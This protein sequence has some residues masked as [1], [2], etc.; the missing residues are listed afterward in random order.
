MRYLPLL[1]L[2]A[3]C[4]GSLPPAPKEVRIPVPVPCISRGDLPPKDFLED[5]ALARLSD[6]D[7]VIALRLDQLNQRTW[8]EKADALLE[9]CVR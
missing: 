6:F 1:L 5:S 8:I 2:L 3:G 4:N 7:F 9:A